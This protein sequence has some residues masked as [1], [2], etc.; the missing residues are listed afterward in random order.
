MTRRALFILLL[1]LLSLPALAAP[2]TLVCTSGGDPGS[3]VCYPSYLTDYFADRIDPE[4]R[5]VGIPRWTVSGEGAVRVVNLLLYVGDHPGKIRV[6]STDGHHLLAAEEWFGTPG[7]TGSTEV[8]MPLPNNVAVSIAWETEGT[9]Y[10]RALVVHDAP[11]HPQCCA[12]LWDSETQDGY[13]WI[14][15]EGPVPWER[16]R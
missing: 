10:F 6:T 11:S 12:V 15:N 4:T 16:G 8:T 9:K 2:Q 13:R 5:R 1:T 7:H 14:A 3:G